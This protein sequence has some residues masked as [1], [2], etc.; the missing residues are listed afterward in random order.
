MTSEAIVAVSAAVVALVQLLHMPPGLAADD[1]TDH[2]TM[3]TE[4]DGEF[5]LEDTA[6]RIAGSDL[7]NL[8]SSEF[9]FSIPLATGE[10]TL[11]G[12]I[13][14]ILTPRPVEEMVRTHTR[15]VITAMTT[16]VPTSQGSDGQ[17]IG[18]SVSRFGHS[19]RQAEKPVSI[20][21]FLSSPDPTR[22]EIRD[23][24]GNRPVFV[25]LGPKANIGW[26]EAMLIRS[27]GAIVPLCFTR[28]NPWFGAVA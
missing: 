13:S 14:E 18:E 6:C 3:N 8:L 9:C 5:S 26:N 19:V 28:K 17:L 11:I 1:V 16:V 2:R 4:L 12:T 21:A 15:T 23:M 22:S 10:Q 27:H 24:I 7:S 25:D 20:P